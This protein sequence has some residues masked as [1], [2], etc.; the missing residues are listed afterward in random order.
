M[1]EI[2]P[3][4]LQIY[5]YITRLSSIVSYYLDIHIWT[6]SISNRCVCH[7]TYIQ[8]HRIITACHT[9]KKVFTSRVYLCNGYSS[10]SVLLQLWWTCFEVNADISISFWKTCFYEVTFEKYILYHYHTYLFVWSLTDPVSVCVYST[11]D[12]RTNKKAFP[13]TFFPF[14]TIF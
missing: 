5:I 2:E 3:V 8:K 4:D 9:M 1:I 11:P 13:I 6:G 7:I 12:K 10:C 14:L